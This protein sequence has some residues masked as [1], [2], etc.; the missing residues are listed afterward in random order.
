MRQAQASVKF[1][2]SMFIFGTM[3]IFV[4]NIPLPSGTVAFFRGVIGFLF[5]LLLCAVLKKPISTANI[6]RN[7]W[8]LLGSGMGMGLTWIFLYGSFARTTVATATL[9]FYFA[10]V[11]LMVV[12]PLL[13]KERLVPY[14]VVCL[15]MAVLGMVLYSG[16]L[17]GTA[18]GAGDLAG[19]AFG[20][21]AAVAYASVTLISKFLNR[22]SPYETTVSQI[23][24]AALVLLPYMLLTGGAS[25]L[26]NLTGFGA[27]NLLIVGIFHTAV[28]FFLFFSS[29]PHLRTLTVAV[30]SYVDPL[31][32]ILASAL[33]LSEPFGTVQFWGTVLIFAST[34][35]NTV[36][37][38]QMAKRVSAA[39]D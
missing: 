27:L 16:F 9:S 32:A 23:A 1:L 17:T 21:M 39:G 20:L 11:I 2:L 14:K 28:T 34:M 35:I 7:R 33:V 4:R 29:I 26:P 36:C 3:G 5:M 8:L 30:L 31:T 38:W 24:V 22:I 18:L 25:A 6:R 37:E 10:P 15:L 19:I 12:S 13:M